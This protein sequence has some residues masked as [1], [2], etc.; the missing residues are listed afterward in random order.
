MDTKIKMQFDPV[1]AKDV[2]VDCAIMF[3]NIEFWVDTNKKNNI[4]NFEGR[5]WTF[6][7]I[8]AFCE[9]FP[10]WTE[11]NIKTILKK[12]IER[13]YIVKGRF[14]KKGYDKT[15]W[16]SV[17]DKLELT[18]HQLEL[19][20]PLVRTNQPI[21]DNKPYNK[22]NININISSEEET[23]QKGD[24]I[25]LSNER[26]KTPVARL[27]SLYGTLFNRLYGFK[28]KPSSYPQTG[29]V[30]KGLLKDY[31]EIQIACLLIVFFNWKGMNDKDEKENEWLVKNT[32]SPFQ[33]KAGLNKYEAYVRNIAGWSEEFENDEKLYPIVKNYFVNKLSTG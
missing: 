28:P 9:Q 4:N 16:Y 11:Q 17:V 19:T 15:S 12:L 33:L 18:N 20:N 1:I 3:S 22:P 29:S 32:H 5:F 13:G 31:S 8:R 30:F 21:P 14:N 7:S 27:Q 23:E 26:G 6:N 25:T 24:E 2:G 10:F